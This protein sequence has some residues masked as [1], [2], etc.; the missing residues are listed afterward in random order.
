MLKSKSIRFLVVFIVALAGIWVALQL[1]AVLGGTTPPDQHPLSGLI[2]VLTGKRK[3]GIITWVLLGL[4]GLGVII[5]AALYPVDTQDSNSVEAKNRLMRAQKLAQAASS[6][7]LAKTTDS[8]GLLL[9]T[10]D[11]GKTPVFQSWESCSL[12]FMGARMGKTTGYV[13]PNALQAPGPYILTTNKYDGVAEVIAAR[14]HRGRI[15]IFDPE[16]VLPKTEQNSAPWM[17]WDLWSRVNTKSDAEAVAKIL[18]HSTKLT[19]TDTVSSSDSFFEPK[20]YALAVALL[21]I[22]SQQRMKIYDLHKLLVDGNLSRLEALLSKGFPLLALDIKGLANQPDKTRDNI[23]AGASRILGPIANDM[24]IKWIE[25]DGSADSFSP[26]SFVR[27]QDTLIVLVKDGGTSAASLSSL[28]VDAVFAAASAAAAPRLDPPLVADLDEINNTV[29]IKDLPDRY[30]YYGSKGLVVNAYLQAYASGEKLWGKTGYKQIRSAA[31]VKVV[32][33]GL[34]DKEE[35][36]A[37]SAMIGK[38]ERSTSSY[39][40]NSSS[41]GTS[42]V[43]RRTSSHSKQW[44]D[45]MTVSELANLPRYQ[46]VVRIAGFGSGIVEKKPWFEDEE[47][48]AAV[49]ATDVAAVARSLGFE[50]TYS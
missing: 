16:A 5:L 9:G 25:P 26:D 1:G 29:H 19:D 21:F 48:S 6:T 34:E 41:G 50:P 13:I 39:S 38:Y 18:N 3:A 10:I 4:V 24:V 28:L 44:H 46:A 2:Q 17:Q 49:S 8:R 40:Y 35:L 42:S 22:A 45:I 20:S 11:K 23:L 43:A 12:I 33:G 32:G 27:S 37:L 7:N 36:E 30:T 14:G 47:F 31:T 15:W